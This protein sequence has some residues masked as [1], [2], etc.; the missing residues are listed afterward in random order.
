MSLAW[1]F[2]LDAERELAGE[3]TG[4]RPPALAPAAE[5]KMRA[6][7]SLLSRPLG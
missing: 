3:R 6:A 2:N 5:R 4:R 7:A 1:V